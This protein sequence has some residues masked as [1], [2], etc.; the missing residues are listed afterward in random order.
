MSRTSKL[1]AA[2]SIA[3]IG[4]LVRYARPTPS[5]TGDAHL[6]HREPQRETVEQ[7][8]S[9]RALLSHQLHAA[10][11]RIRELEAHVATLERLVDD[12]LAN[13]A[14][15]PI[16]EHFDGVA[17]SDELAD[18]AD[19]QDP[20]RALEE[21]F[22]TQVVDESWAPSFRAD[23]LAS[24]SKTSLDDVLVVDQIDCRETLCRIDLRL[25][26]DEEDHARTIDRL[27][28]EWLLFGQP[29]AFT[30]PGP[31]QLSRDTDGPR[32]AVFLE[33]SRAS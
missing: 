29:C 8:A 1:L 19:A 18:T 22:A 11:A 28:R 23:L 31:S 2:V 20:A 32:H 24:F 26:S 17:P 15:S 33:C 4:Y 13:D 6:A 25:S 9:A 14:G 10:D 12:R 16:R 21:Q 27:G 3:A 5:A 30:L 7:D